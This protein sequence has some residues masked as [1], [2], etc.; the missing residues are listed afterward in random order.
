MMRGL[1]ITTATRRLN[2]S[3]V[4]VLKE[5]ISATAI[6]IGTEIVIGIKIERETESAIEIDYAIATMIE[7]GIVTVMHLEIEEKEKIVIPLLKIE[8]MELENKITEVFMLFII[9]I[10][11]FADIDSTLDRRFKRRRSLSPRRP[12]GA[13]GGDLYI[14]DYEK[15]GYAPG[16]R[17]GKPTEMR[18]PPP[19]YPV[20]PMG[21]FHI[22]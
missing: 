15:D 7:I 6:A 10:L 14:P 16:P 17:Y 21:N 9:A 5:E 2:E 20:M 19:P 3:V 8:V 11:F 22:K 12:E 4:R 18:Y 13:L 1:L